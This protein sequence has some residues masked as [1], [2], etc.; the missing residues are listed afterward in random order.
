MVGD[1]ACHTQLLGAVDCRA[2]PQVD[3]HLGA[4]RDQPSVLSDGAGGM[5]EPDDGVEAELPS[6][7]RRYPPTHDR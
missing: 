4:Q 2:C 6:A 3:R 1:R 5:S 7:T